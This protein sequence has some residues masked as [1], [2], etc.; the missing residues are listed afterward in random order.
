[1]GKVQ[2][3]L[4]KNGADPKTIET[5]KTGVGNYWKSN[6]KDKFQDFEFYKGPNESTI[7]M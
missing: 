2:D 7:G 6:I 3:I 5:F 1:M 4:E